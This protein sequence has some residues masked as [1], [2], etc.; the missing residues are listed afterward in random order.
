MWRTSLSSLE[1]KFAVSKYYQTCPKSRDASDPRCQVESGGSSANVRPS[2][3]LRSWRVR[4]RPL[5]SPGPSPRPCPRLGPRTS[6][7]TS[8]PYFWPSGSPRTG[9]PS[10]STSV[11]AHTPVPAPSPPP[12]CRRAFVSCELKAKLSGGGAVERRVGASAT[13]YAFKRAAPFAERGLSSFLESL[14]WTS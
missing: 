9:R 10:A 3:R 13:G 7:L 6:L 1:T 14:I 8:V 11:P 2:W 12:P 5:R 4:V